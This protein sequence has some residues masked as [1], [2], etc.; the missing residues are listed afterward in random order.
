MWKI[1]RHSSVSGCCSLS[2]SNSGLLTI[3]SNTSLL[4]L[5][6]AVLQDKIPIVS[7]SAPLSRVKKNA[8]LMSANKASPTV[9]CHAV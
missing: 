1:Y 2:E 5:S 7:F 8:T 6:L 9:F 4:L 3:D